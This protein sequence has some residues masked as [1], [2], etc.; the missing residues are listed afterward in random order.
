MS[1]PLDK[2][3]LAKLKAFIDIC[4]AKPDIFKF[5]ELNFFKDY[6]ESLGGKIPEPEMT[7]T[8][9]KIPSEPTGPSEEAEN[10][11]VESDP[12]SLLEFDTTGCI[13]PDTINEEIQ[14]M[15]ELDKEVTQEEEDL[16]DEKRMEA[17]TQFSQGNFNKA[18]EFYGEAIMLNPNSALLYSKRGQVYLKLNKPN[19]CIK[20]CSRALELNCDSAPAFKFRGRAYRLLGE[21]EKAAQD[22]RQAVKIDYDEQSDE[23]LKEVQPIAQKIEQHNLKVERKK[24]EKE[25]KQRQERIRK[26][27]E[28]HAKTA[29]QAP[30]PEMGDIYKL[31]QDPE[32]MAAFQDP[33]VA[34]AFQDISTNP[35]NFIKYQNNPK[36]KTVLEK[37]SSKIGPNFPGAGAFPAGFPGANPTS[38]NVPPTT[39]DDDALD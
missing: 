39:A 30:P 17:V 14:V 27:K 10:V 4:I 6:I 37:L 23:W 26:S 21:W 25:E 8:E 19:A 35:A 34:A 13:E 5:P 3:S 22:L 15:G 24:A 33:D 16:A 2:E 36:I 1:C 7:T 38:A 32:I 11:E 18:I 31:L 9:E 28:A 29:S 20:D 12:E